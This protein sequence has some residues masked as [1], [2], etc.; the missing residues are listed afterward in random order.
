MS[1]LGRVTRLALLILLSTLTTGCV[2]FDWGIYPEA[3]PG[4]GIEPSRTC[5]TTITTPDLQA[6]IEL[7][8]YVPA[9]FFFGLLVPVI[10]L[11]G[12]I[13]P[14]DRLEVWVVLKGGTGSVRP[15]SL[16]LRFDST[17]YAPSSTRTTRVGWQPGQTL[18]VRH[19]DL[20]TYRF[21]DLRAPR[22]RFT[23]TLDGLPPVDFAPALDW[24]FEYYRGN[25]FGP[26][27]V[28]HRAICS[29]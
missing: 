20:I 29:D 8:S 24:R 5:K 2:S 21:Q 14:S 22:S 15:D 9:I 25:F 6:D 12:F 19:R 18:L 27:R 17:E 28:G 13:F 10:P 1:K 23:L 16:R 7:K 26:P 4:P 11:P 3:S